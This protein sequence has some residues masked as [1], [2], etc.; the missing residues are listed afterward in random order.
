MFRKTSLLAF[1]LAAFLSS[2]L[3]ASFLVA[4]TSV[5]PVAEVMSELSAGHWQ[6]YAMTPKN[7][8]PHEFT[9][10][11]EEASHFFASK[12]YVAVGMEADVQLI[13]R[14]S[15]EM[16]VVRVLPELAA[17]DPHLW[18]DAEGLAALAKAV[19]QAY[20]KA[21]PA[22]LSDYAAANSLFL[23]RLD[24][25]DGRAKEILAPFAGRA[26]VVHHG[27]F[28]RYAAANGLRQVALEENEKE[29]S[30]SRIAE[31]AALVAKEKICI[32]YA[33]PGHNPAPLQSIAA[34]TGATL[35]ELDALPRDPVEALA[36][37]AR[38]L[39]AGFEAKGADGK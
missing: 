12:L 20:G 32:L 11:P 1:A 9:L 15:K 3:H 35:R 28:A 7:R 22:H 37:R 24:N 39:A 27:A 29:P 21:D 33:Q 6:V 17:T 8:D 19:T 5:A 26:F 25:A 2:S 36:D 13:P 4:T 34:S 10:R 31:V 30:A 14:A 38:E 18:L 16:D 23:A